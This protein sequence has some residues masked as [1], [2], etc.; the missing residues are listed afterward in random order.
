MTSLAF[1]KNLNDIREKCFINKLSS[2]S[3]TN[4]SAAYS[5]RLLKANYTGP[6]VNVRRSSDN[7][8]M[9]FFGNI[10]GYIGSRISGTGQSL[11]E[12]LNGATGSI[13][14]FYDQ[15]GNQRNISQSVN[16]NQPTISG[17]N[18]TF[19][20]STHYLDTTN[21]PL[22][23]GLDT[24]TFIV[25]WKPTTVNS[26]NRIIEQF[27]GTTSSTC[28][29][30]LSVNN[31]YG[32]NGQFNDAHNM[33]TFQNNVTRK[34]VMMCNHNLSTNNI[35]MN[36]NGTFYSNTTSSP[37]TLAVSV[38][39]F[40]VGRKNN[41]AE[42]FTGT[43]NEILIFNNTLTV[44]E[45]MLYYTPN[46]ITR[47]K[48]N[49]SP[50]IQL[51]S[52]LKDVNSIPGSTNN[53]IGWAFGF[54]VQYLNLSNNA[55]ITT[56]SFPSGPTVF[57]NPVYKILSGSNTAITTPPYIEMTRASSQYLDGG[58]RTLNIATNG[59]F[60]AIIY[61][62]FTGS[63]GNYERVFDF[64]S[65]TTDN[66]INNDI[67]LF[68]NATNTLL[69]CNVANGA[70]WLTGPNTFTTGS[71]TIVQNTWYVLCVRYTHSSKLLEI[72]QNG[73]TLNSM[74]LASQLTDR[75][76]NRTFIGRSEYTANAY[77][78]I[79]ISGAYFYDSY[80]TDIQVSAISNHLLFPTTSSITN[81]LPNYSN[82]YKQ[83]IVLSQ[84]YKQ[85]QAMKFNGNI[86]SFIDILDLPALP[87]TYCF[88]FNC[89]NT[90][91]NTVVGLCD[92]NRGTNFGIQIDIVGGNMTI[93][94]ALP[95]TWSSTT[96]YAITANT[97]YHITMVVNLSFQVLVYINGSLYQTLTGTAIP[98]ARSRIIVGADGTTSKGYFGYIYDFKVFDYILRASEV[99]NIYNDNYNKR[100]LDYKS[101]INYIVNSSN[102]YN[103]MTLNN[104]TG[105]AAAT[106]GSDPNV[107]YRLTL[108]G[109]SNFNIFSNSTRIQDYSS[110]TCSFE[111][112]TDT[113][114]S[115][116]LF[117]FCG[118]T[119]VTGFAIY[120]VL[121]SNSF[122]LTF[123][124]YSPN[125]I[126]IHLR[127][128]SSTTVVLAPLTNWV[129]DSNW[130]PVTVTYT[131]G[132][133]NTWVVNFNGVDIITYSNVD[134][135]S[136]RSSIAG[137]NWGIGSR[138]GGGDMTS[139]I[140][141]VELTYKPYTLSLNSL[142]NI[143]HNIH[144]FPISALTTNTT[145]IPGNSP[146]N[147]YYI[148]N[149]STENTSNHAAW[150]CFRN[151]YTDNFGWTSSSSVYN[152]TT[153]VY[154]G[155]VSTTVS[156]IAYTGEWVQIQTP[157]NL[158]LVSFSIL[159]RQDNS[160]S[161][162]SPIN[163]VIAGSN[164][165]ATWDAIHIITGVT[166]TTAEQSFICNQ[167]NSKKYI[168]F[169]LISRAIASE[170]NDGWTGFKNWSLFSALFVK[171]ITG[172]SIYPPIPLTS[173]S[174][175]ISGKNYGNGT[176]ITTASIF[177]SQGSYNAWHPFNLDITQPWGSNGYSGA[178]QGATT[179]TVS[180]VSQPG[181]WVQ[182][183]LPNQILLSHCS[184]SSNSNNYVPISFVIAG[185]NNGSTWDSL[186]DKTNHTWINDPVFSNHSTR[187]IQINAI[188][189]YKYFRLIS[190]VVGTDWI[191]INEWK[192][193]DSSLQQQP[194]L[195]EG[196]TWKFFNGYHSDSM[197]FTKTN[198]Y[199]NIDTAIDFT[200]L[201]SATSGQYYNGVGL[202][203]FTIECYGYFK[204]NVTGIWT[205]NIGSDDTGYLWMGDIAL[206]GY[207]TGNYICKSGIG[208]GTIKL[209]SGV[210]YPIRILYGE[211]AGAEDLTVTF[212]PPGGSATTNGEGYYFSSIGVN[213]AYPAESAK[214]IKDLIG[215]NTDGVYYINVNGISTATYCLMNDQYDG[216]GWMMLMKATTGTTFEY[217]STHWSTTS[218]LNTI[219]TTRTNSDAKY[220][221]FNYNYIKD[222]MAIWP[223]I[224]PDNYNNVYGHPG[225]CF[226]VNDGWVWK[227]NNWNGGSRTTALAGF[228]NTRFPAGGTGSIYQPLDINNPFNYSGFS[229]TL[230]SYQTGSYL[231]YFNADLNFIHKSRWGFMWNNE[232]TEFATSEAVTGI[233]LFV[234]G[235]ANHSAGDYYL[236]NGTENINRSARVEL[237]GR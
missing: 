145:Y 89:T 113:G 40:T 206:T 196:L 146:A 10:H 139:Y 92:F 133:V 103:V 160:F 4:C 228:Q 185:S 63:A 231:H 69:G 178:Y 199:S 62:A 95:S 236:S 120:E 166:W 171:N 134:N 221:V 108:A 152:S 138:S 64:T 201:K 123:S 218:T 161:N 211:Q 216:G 65:S 222:V 78:S 26:L 158:Q 90:T 173:N 29:A 42:Y 237:F 8:T 54:D 229:N 16:A 135:E 112:K 52:I 106:S 15:S 73:I 147:G 3:Q 210:Y 144:K 32:F 1:S 203:N 124:V 51:K 38:G 60:T 167:N 234:N 80:L 25:N 18:I 109:G 84:S 97:W 87:I 162:R 214:V 114:G 153:G 235:G 47:K 19:N 115:D 200:S 132:T 2:Y 188:D 45:S 107:Q 46:L 192:L 202:D 24:Y 9:D 66:A 110:F 44:T 226:Y 180:G 194:G 117:F 136:W 82:I 118:A 13:V 81:I 181:E 142:R 49:N 175:V 116:G 128:D 100:L 55:S 122:M 224:N 34:S 205:F 182:I 99:T 58:A 71:G 159:P 174:T 93:F 195:I 68:R 176:Y 232:T 43:I 79:N 96:A 183:Q 154:I 21:A 11:N 75:T 86:N 50:V 20:G 187:N 212:T 33:I 101:S 215:T 105:V 12:W 59:G 76:F 111:L 172:S 94:A 57:N 177:E 121:S 27:S 23:A 225:G 219:D 7:A 127:N 163:F 213:S 85:D 91:N 193:Y 150:K 22:T 233:G 164:D 102:W 217:S 31:N 30:L 67:S 104:I 168:Q 17:T 156:S 53:T 155:A 220:N 37:S 131:R 83:G 77:S 198:T 70:T 170:S 61:C 74:T 143:G 56:A 6:M 36:D 179:T 209:I 191:F 186:Y 190:R 165:G 230:F 35:T 208:N 88:W 207:T 184:I 129:A 126:G 140:R 48:Q 204:A 14:I 39:L 125:T 119:S 137:N 28:A 189:L 169:R 227:V 148:S 157:N 130:Y 151:D 5:L 72:I 141:K 98:P 149:A 223:D 197:T 41:S